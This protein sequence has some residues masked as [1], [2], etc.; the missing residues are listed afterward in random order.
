MNLD[1]KRKLR[2]KRV[3]R[4]RRHV[5]GTA[6]RPRL[7]VHFSNK[8]IFAQAIDDR[9]GHTLLALST[10]DKGLQGENCTANTTS[11][12]RLGTAFAERSLA[13][14]VRKVV[15]DRNGRRYHGAVKSF[16]EAARQGGLEF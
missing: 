12:A 8:N 14:G 13:A 11:A 9:R 7:C 5:K 15:F 3:W 6:E 4:I 1:Q 2:Q 16:A 10:L